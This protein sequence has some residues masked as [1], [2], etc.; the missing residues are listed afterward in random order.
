MLFDPTFILVI[1]AL[2]LALLAQQ[3]VKGNYKKF[4][5]IPASIGLTGAELA[6]KMLI[7]NGLDGIDIQ[8]VKGILTDNY[9]PVKKIIFLSEG[10]YNS[11]SLAA[12]AI[13]AHET[14]HALQ[15][16][17]GYTPVKIR[18]S[19]LPSASIGS[20]LAFPLFFIGLLLTNQVL[21]DIGIWFFGAA[22]LFQLV[23]LP[24]EF[25]A[26]ARALQ[27]LQNGYLRDTTEI[28]GAR[29]VL[30]AA[31]LTYVAATLMALVQF[32]RL[33]FLRGSRS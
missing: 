3:Q 23:T 32:L 7:D 2:I 22:L 26:S 15:Y 17:A 4:S 21:M 9:H 27:Y 6:R 8:P 5:R 13:A 12:L 1:I 11:I 33:I 10:V 24:V 20:T 16:A 14:G 31:A 29:A 19:L 18:G 25:N 28:Q 30:R